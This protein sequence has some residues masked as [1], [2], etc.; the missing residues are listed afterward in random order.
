MPL[1]VMSSF[2]HVIIFKDPRPVK[3][4]KSTVHVYVLYEPSTTTSNTYTYALPCFCPFSAQPIFSAAQAQRKEK[5]AGQPSCIFLCVKFFV[6]FS[7]WIWGF[8]LTV[9]VL[10][11]QSLGSWVWLVAGALRGVPQ[12]PSVRQSGLFCGRRRVTPLW[13]R[14]HSLTTEGG[15]EVATSNLP[16]TRERGCETRNSWNF[17]VCFCY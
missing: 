4:L 13:R 15:S 16:I 12:G 7:A 1:K 8:W 3:I 5:R 9:V 14:R 17:R 10:R 11:D 2:T 6:D